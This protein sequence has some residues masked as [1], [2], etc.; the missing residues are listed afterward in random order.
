MEAARAGPVQDLQAV[1]VAGDCAVQPPGVDVTPA[2]AS[3][4]G[5]ESWGF[6]LHSNTNTVTDPSI[7]VNSGYSPSSLLAPPPFNCA[8]SPLAS[9]PYTVS[10]ASLSQ[11]DC[12]CAQLASAFAV[13]EVPGFASSRSAKP[14]EIPPTG[15]NQTEAATL[16]I[17]NPDLVGFV[18]LNIISS[19]PGSTYVSSS[20][21]QGTTT[22]P[23][24]GGVQ[25]VL[26]TALNQS[27]TFTAVIN[28]PNPF[29]KPFRS[30]PSFDFGVT[31]S[32]ASSVDSGPTSSETIAVPTLDGGSSGAG[33]A[34]F[35]VSGFSGSWELDAAPG[36]E[37]FY[38][39]TPSP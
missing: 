37:V 35:A 18:K 33:S 4:L 22:F 2:S 11:G 8:G 36:S 16:D 34:T 27:Y 1:V 31:G 38:Q 23:E 12:L 13:D 17:T 5:R 9:L 25:F 6:Q 21:P 3:L 29:R 26:F 32:G 39:P 15:R 28:V 14:F 7:T 19:V 24:A 30:E 10:Q 20:A